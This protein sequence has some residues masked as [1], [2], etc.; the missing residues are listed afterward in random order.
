MKL[1]L[2]A[3]IGALAMIFVGLL[4]KT[5]PEVSLPLSV[6]TFW[7]ALCYGAILNQKKENR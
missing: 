2:T 3:A 5:A 4:L 6:T 7:G 1:L